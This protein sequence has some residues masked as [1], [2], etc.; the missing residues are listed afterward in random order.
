MPCFIVQY[1]LLFLILLSMANLTRKK[2][3]ILVQELI[4]SIIFPE[5]SI[6]VSSTVSPIGCYGN[7]HHIT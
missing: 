1:T 7:K 3:P 4:D 5:A 2:Q 6:L